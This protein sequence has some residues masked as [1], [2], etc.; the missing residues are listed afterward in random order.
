MTTDRVRDLDEAVHLRRELLADGYTDQQLRAMVG[1]GVLHRVR[2][3][4]YVD[5]PLW[6]SLGAADR[7]RVLSRAVLKSSHPTTVL[8]HASAAVERGVP[9]W[10]I[11]LDE[12]HTTRTDG[13]G[14]RREAGIV[15]HV[16]GLDDSDVETIN[17]VRVSRVPRCAVEI[18]SITSTEPAL[19]AVNGML[20]A[21]LM[22]YDELSAAAR[23][24]RHWPS[25]ISANLV[26]HL[27][28]GRMESVAETRTDFLCWS[29]HLPRPVPQVVIRDENGREVAR[30]DFAWPDLKVFLEFDGRIKYER[31]RRAGE[32]L[33]Q[34]L[35]REKR[36]EEM[37]CLL[38]G[39]T[40][41]RITWADLERPAATA[42]RI[43]SLLSSR[44]PSVG[45]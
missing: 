28:D 29:Q 9:L 16:G 34:Y 45:A 13:R 44:S 31:F 25:T 33:E 21:G 20:H 36:R 32:T 14:A 40:C 8:T 42:Q 4:A 30:V 19:V 27:A 39:W 23:E 2:R 15:H 7:H 41:I 6:D 18:I 17:G 43:R 11:P 38:T 22:T 35:M 1:D 37:V 24:M 5:K 3:G 12:V 26:L 10:G